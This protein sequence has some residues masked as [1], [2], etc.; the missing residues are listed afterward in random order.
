VI[1]DVGKVTDSSPFVIVYTDVSVGVFTIVWVTFSYPAWAWG[2]QLFSGRMK[3]CGSLAVFPRFKGRKNLFLCSSFFYYLVV[4]V[5]LIINRSWAMRLTAWN[6]F[7]L[8]F[9]GFSQSG[10]I[11]NLIFVRR[12]EI[13]HGFVQLFLWV[14]INQIKTKG[15]LV[16]PTSNSSRMS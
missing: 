2:V 10:F 13:R 8:L 9:L 3:H 4:A 1:T 5:A 7:L 16:R 14:N 11:K 12:L 15:H 6:Y